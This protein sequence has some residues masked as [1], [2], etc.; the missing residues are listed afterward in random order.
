M[1][2][3]A[4][5]YV[6]NFRY[7]R[8]GAVLKEGTKTVFPVALPEAEKVF[9]ALET[10]KRKKGYVAEGENPGFIAETIPVNSGKNS[11]KKHKVIISLLKGAL[12][13]DEHETWPLSRIIWRA[14]ELGIIEAV[15]LIIKLADKTDPLQLYSCIWALSKLG[16]Q[17]AIPFFQEILKEQHPAYL[18]NLTQAALLNTGDEDT[19]KKQIAALTA[20]LPESLKQ[21]ILRDDHFLNAYCYDLFAKFGAGSPVFLVPFYLV[22]INKGRLRTAFIFAIKEI[23][24][25]A[26]SFKLVRQLFK[27]SE[28]L[29]DTQV[30][31]IL[32][33]LIEK[34]SF[35]FNADRVYINNKWITAADELKKENSSLA[36]SKKTKEYFGRRIVRTLTKLGNDKSPLYTKY[37]ADMLLTFNDQ[38][39]LA[40]PEKKSRVNYLYN[41]SSRTYTRLE[42][43]TWFDTYSNYRALYFILYA[44][45][46]RYRLP[47]KASRWQC[48]GPYEPGQA[49]QPMRE[50]AFAL[51]WNQAPDEIIRLLSYSNCERVSD[52]ALLVFQNNAAF[53]ELVKE[54]DLLVFIKNNA[55][56]TQALGFELVK[57][58][59][60]AEVPSAS[61]IVALLLSKIAAARAFA[62]EYIDKDPLKFANDPE[63]MLVILLSTDLASHTWLNAFLLNNKADLYSLQQ[64]LNSLLDE[65]S[66]LAFIPQEDHMASIAGVI[67][68]V[69]KEAVSLLDPT[70]IFGL[71]THPNPVIQ[72]FAG[73]LLSLCKIDPALV[74][75]ALIFSL[76]QSENKM[77]RKAAIDLLGQLQAKDLAEKQSLVLSLCLS[78][79]QD[80]RQSA[81]KLVDKLLQ[82][83]PD[84][85]YGLLNLFIPVL[86]VKEKYDGLHDDIFQLISG[87]LSAYLSQIGSKQVLALCASRYLASQELGNLLLEKNIQP[88][89]LSIKEYNQLANS[90]LLKNRQYVLAY[91]STAIDRIKAEKKEAVMLTDSVWQDVRVF[92]FTFF[93][94]HF[95]EQDWEPELFIAL[96]DSTKEDVQAFGREMITKWFENDEGFDYLLKLSQ[97]PDSRMQLFA[98]GFLDRYA[99]NNLEMLKKLGDFFITL[100]SN[101]NKGR[102]AKIRAIGLLSKE[103]IADEQYAFLISAIFNRMSATASIQDKALYIKAMFEISKVF[104]SV[105]LVIKVKETP[106]YKTKQITHAV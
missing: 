3:G 27:I 18:L 86:T 25:K 47:A 19:R 59:Y 87:K 96:C 13:D 12:N 24:V 45:S 48:V 62:M 38:Q 51:L 4:D 35:T 54:E 104:P 28:M 42:I 80:V 94:T 95:G 70:L 29:N 16:D 8:R 99:K 14:G 76:L 93:R 64:V 11:N 30:Y 75:D 74:P 78:P 65:I 90:S 46:T 32:S 67:E 40:P 84:V 73:K 15:P 26:G 57:E 23:P 97:H 66:S 34:A 56:K 101:I 1:E 63:L 33:K 21:A 53:K 55:L 71:L 31:A 83:D 6:V 58:R 102:T 82:A 52:F 2:T 60:T 92:A 43:N 10:E 85:G 17:K 50:E 20:A 105:D 77:A 9:E 49:F 36:F 69:F 37:A 98:S 39:D 22:S 81:Q 91:Y 41:A 89:A 5:A 44:N 103:A 72:G 106:V 68:S 88:G 100:L 79:L 61:I 7:G